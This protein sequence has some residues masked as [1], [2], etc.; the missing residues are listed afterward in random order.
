[1]AR[2]VSEQTGIETLR[3]LTDAD[4]EKLHFDASDVRVVAVVG[5]DALDRF[6]ADS[7]ICQKAGSVEGGE[8][9]LCNTPTVNGMSSFFFVG[10][11]QYD[12]KPAGRVG[13]WTW[14]A[15]SPDG[16][17]IL[18]EWSAECEVP[19]V[20]LIPVATG[21]PRLVTG[22]EAEAKG[23]TTDGRAIMVKPQGPCGDGS[24]PGTYLVTP[25]GEATRI[26][27]N[28]LEALQPSVE[29]RDVS[30]IAP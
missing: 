8:L 12:V 16:K 15:A 23:W 28:V 24:N 20:A 30:A 25:N 1:V 10:R 11:E 9:R 21:K 17:T 19:Q 29:P 6:F 26:T 4:L 27:S 22:D 2:F 18:G 13:H 5:D 14:A 7:D 3:P